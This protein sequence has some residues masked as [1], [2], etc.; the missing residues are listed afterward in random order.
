MT[1]DQ[2]QRTASVVRTVYEAYRDRRRSDAEALL[3]PDFRFTSPYDDGIDRA[4]FFAR[5]WPNGDRI[6]GFEIERIA[7]GPDG[8]FITYR[9]I[10]SD[11]TMFRNT[12]Y[13]TVGNG[14]VT[15]AD[16]YFGASYRDG[17]FVPKDEE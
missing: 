4:A 10:A 9:C 17:V 5:C 6:R 12:E 1:E 11:G 13:L 2:A 14:Q 7:P 16:V 3:A 15:S 8:A